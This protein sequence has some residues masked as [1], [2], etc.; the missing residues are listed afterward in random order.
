MNITEV[1]ITLAAFIYAMEGDLKSLIK[2]YITPYYSDLK[3]LQDKHLENRLLERLKK[4]L[5]TNSE[6]A[7]VDELIEY[8]DFGDTIII[9]RK[10]K[11]FIPASIMS[12]IDEY[13]QE[14][15]NIIPIRNRVMHTRPLLNGDFNTVYKLVQKLTSIKDSFWDQLKF[16]HISI[17][18][19]PNY[20]L[21]LNLP[22]KVSDSELTSVSHNLPIPDFDETGLIGRTRDVSEIINLVLSNKVVTILG[23]GGIGKSAVCLKVA[24]DIVDMDNNCPFELVIWTTAKSTMLTSAGIKHINSTIKDYAGLIRN[25][26]GQLELNESEP[27][28]EILDYLETFKV[29][30]IIDNL[31]TIHNETIRNFIRVAQTK[32]HILITSRIRLGELE[33]PRKLSGLSANDSAN[34]IR[35]VGKMR[36]SEIL[37]KLPNQTLADISKKLYFNPLALKWFVSLVES[38]VQPSEVLNHKDD[39]LNFCLTNVYD[40]ISDEAKAT[41]N[42]IRASRRKLT[43]GEIIYISDTEPM[44]VRS[45]IIELLKT[46][47][48]SRQITDVK[49]VESVEHY[50]SDFARDFLSRNYKI[51]GGYIRHI[52]SKYRELQNSLKTASTNENNDFNIN[53][54]TYTTKN[55]KVAAKF[56]IE[57]LRYSRQHEFDKAIARVEEARDIDPSFSEV[58]RVSAFIKATQGDIL[59]AEDDYQTGLEITPINPKILYFYSQ[60]LLFELDEVDKALEYAVQLNDLLPDHPYSK[61]LLSR[62]YSKDGRYTQ[63]IDLLHDMLTNGVVSVEDKVIIGTDLIDSYNKAGS[64]LLSGGA[65]DE[66]AEHFITAFKLYEYFTDEYYSDRRMNKRF[67]HTLYKFINLLSVSQIENQKSY[68]ASLVEKYEKTIGNSDICDKVI[69]VYFDKFNDASFDYL[70]KV[71]SDHLKSGYLEH[72]DEGVN[73]VFIQSESERFYANRSAFID[74]SDDQDW[75]ALHKDQ[76]VQFQ[77]GMNSKG[78]CAVNIK[79]L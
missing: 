50:I 52:T 35:S 21:T 42:V 16:T 65:V 63:A 44:K 9:L 15:S 62:C 64:A 4:D 49:S 19:N 20:V 55:Q 67:I 39:L 2:E 66:G 6:A 54:V 1:R 18:K 79:V 71:K 29:L 68:I 61:I 25:I 77:V 31:E 75:N 58:Y 57:A 73:F 59:D 45:S 72:K 47:L 51:D 22:L 46:T 60:F 78:P 76:T 17:S 40:K 12:G 24:Y 34:L 41:L 8:I 48:I 56:L 28:E 36:N 33:Y 5:D 13:H 37:V 11:H 70:L 69:N 7:T 10:N 26:G 30:L 14:I 32:C 53:F 3:F 74:V 38:G 43:V 27:L 23:D